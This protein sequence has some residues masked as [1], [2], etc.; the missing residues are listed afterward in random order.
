MA[1]AKV[2]LENPRYTSRFVMPMWGKRLAKLEREG[3]ELGLTLAIARMLIQRLTLSHR[4]NPGSSIV[5][6]IQT[7]IGHIENQR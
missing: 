5:Q 1:K 6:T 4:M 2:N 7:L 3:D